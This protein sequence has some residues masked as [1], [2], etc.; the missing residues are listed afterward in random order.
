MAERDKAC[1]AVFK[2]PH[3]SKDGTVTVCCT[4][5]RLLM[6]LGNLNEKSLE[7]IWFGERAKEIRLMHINGEQDKILSCKFCIRN[8]PLPD[9]ELEKYLKYIGKEELFEPYLARTKKL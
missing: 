2:T 4:D 9:R 5:F 1:M 8:F 6:A 3:I 7:E